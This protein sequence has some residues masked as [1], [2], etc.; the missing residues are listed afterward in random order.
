MQFHLVDKVVFSNLSE[1]VVFSY[2]LYTDPASIDVV[3]CNQILLG[4]QWQQAFK[5]ETVQTFY[6]Y[7]KV[8]NTRRTLVGNKIVDHS[9]GWS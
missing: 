3:R 4:E 7:R 2:F 1:H 6:I 8:S 5:T 9:L